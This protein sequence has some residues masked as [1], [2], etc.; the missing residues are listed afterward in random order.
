MFNVI[1][2]ASNCA[3]ATQV[4]HLCQRE[5]SSSS[6][7][8]NLGTDLCAATAAADRFGTNTFFCLCIGFTLSAVQVLCRLLPI[9]LS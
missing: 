7:S 4:L 5:S 3:F 9:S 8:G 2:Y 1:N 6:S